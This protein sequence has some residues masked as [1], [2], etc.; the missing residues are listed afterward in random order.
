MQPEKDWSLSEYQRTISGDVIASW[1][2]VGLFAVQ[3]WMCLGKRSLKLIPLVRISW[4]LPGLLYRGCSSPWPI[5]KSTLNPRTIIY[6]FLCYAIA[7]GKG[8][9]D[10]DG[11][12]QELW[13]LVHM[14]GRCKREN[15]DFWVKECQAEIPVLSHLSHQTIETF[16]P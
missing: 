15:T 5:L 14:V 7:S 3:E 6:G 11:E 13:G 2:T 1:Q 9:F 12:I 16:L 4:D 8:I 10:A